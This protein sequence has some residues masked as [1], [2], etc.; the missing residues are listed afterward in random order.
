[1]WNFNRLF[2]HVLTDAMFI[3][4]YGRT[5]CVPVER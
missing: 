4:A 1:L 3:P 5:D 2:P